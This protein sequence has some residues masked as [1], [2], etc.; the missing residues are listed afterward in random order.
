MSDGDAFI[1]DEPLVLGP[2]TEEPRYWLGWA[3]ETTQECNGPRESRSVTR[4]ETS[5]GSLWILIENQEVEEVDCDTIQPV[6]NVIYDKEAMDR[7]LASCTP[8][9]RQELCRYYNGIPAGVDC[10]EED[11][12]D[13]TLWVKTDQGFAAPLEQ[14]VQLR[15]LKARLLR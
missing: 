11:E 14:A 1:K 8:R 7:I 12:E 2:M 3:L 10:P 9:L 4:L 15:K 13:Y 6:R 5:F